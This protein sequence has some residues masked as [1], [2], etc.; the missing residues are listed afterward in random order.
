MESV[1]NIS[2]MTA[3]KHWNNVEFRDR[4]VSKSQMLLSHELYL[5]DKQSKSF[6]VAPLDATVNKMNQDLRNWVNMVSIKSP[7]TQA[8]LMCRDDAYDMIKTLHNLV[9][10]GTEQYACRE[11][12]YH[13]PPIVK[14]T[15]EQ[16]RR[17]VHGITSSYMILRESNMTALIGIILEDVI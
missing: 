3:I 4:Y 12:R 15:Q 11:Q 9:V 5:V 1:Q 14:Q 10:C 8:L 2:D 7:L 16:S 17:T 6:Y 13:I